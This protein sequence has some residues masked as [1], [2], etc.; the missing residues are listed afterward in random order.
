MRTPKTV[1]SIRA[2][3]ALLSVAVTLIPSRTYNRSPLK[4]IILASVQSCS[5]ERVN[6]VLP[7]RVAYSSVPHGR[8]RFRDHRVLGASGDSSLRV[9]VQNVPSL[10]PSSSLS[11]SPRP[12][13]NR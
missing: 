6:H 8:R 3:P 7:A 4:S 13:R 11:S 1:S 10:A 2:H 12:R 5:L 9:C